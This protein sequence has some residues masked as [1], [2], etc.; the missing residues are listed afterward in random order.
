MGGSDQGK[1][2]DHRL[3]TNESSPV[4]G[5]VAVSAIL[6]LRCVFSDTLHVNF[7]MTHRNHNC[8]DLT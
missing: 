5:V 6:A 8:V 1:L 3:R 2:P 4:F 7:Q